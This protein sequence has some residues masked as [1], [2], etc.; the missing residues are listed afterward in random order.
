MKKIAS[1]INFVRSVEP[2]ERDESY[3]P[4]TLENELELCARYGWRS[5]VLLQYDALIRA[6]Y[7]AILRRYGDAVEPGLWL[8]IVEPLADAAGVPWEGGYVWDWT[9]GVNY[10]QHYSP[11]QRVRLLDAACAGFRAVFGHDPKAV[12]CWILDS[13]SLQYLR[14]TY[15]VEAACI[16]REQVGTDYSTLWGGFYN[17]AYYPCKNNI[18]CPAG[19]RETQIDVPV[20]RMLGP[21]P[22]YQYDMGLGEPEKP[23]GVCT[24]EPVYEE[25]GGCE[26]WVRW[27]LREN[28]GDKCLSHAYAQFGQENSFGWEKIRQGLPMQFRLLDEAVRRGEI[29]LMT[30]CESAA[31]YRDAFSLTAPAAICADSDWKDAGSRTVWY[32]CR[33]YRV[34]ILCR[35][36]EA[37]IR[38]FHLFD[39]RYEDPC[40]HTNNTQP[41]TGC[42]TLPV[43]DGFRFS[44]GGVVAGIRLCRGGAPVR[45]DAP[46]VS[47]AREPDAVTA[48][49]GALRFDCSADRLRV[50]LP[51]DC[52]LVFQT[53]DVPDLPYR[54][55]TDD[56][57]HMAFAGYGNAWYD[58]SLR[59]TR[60][61]YAYDNGAV[62]VLPADGVIEWDTAHK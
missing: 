14:E 34:N 52:E 60:G 27:Y 26:D 38:D 11:A 59:L 42:F 33:N 55:A 54:R 24:L 43:M 22:I 3:L 20:F 23:Q 62:R 32:S 1:I 48:T 40:L 30:L 47:E 18:L 39:D 36:G 21:D 25:G 9:G 46:F 28:Y 2:R 51:P 8:E 44:A 5:T 17:G 53:A 4:V 50:T 29:E 13:F 19:S 15:G 61:R 58:Y 12:G 45:S 35:D 7:Q 57:L 56:T 6:D 10:L 16:C 37:W 49:F 31:W 41:R